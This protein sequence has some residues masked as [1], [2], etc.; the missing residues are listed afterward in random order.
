[1]N[2]YFS[3]NKIRDLEPILQETLVKVLAKMQES[4]AAGIPIELRPLFNAAT[5]DI[6]TEYAFGECWNSLGAADLNNEFFN[7]LNSGGQMWHVSSYFPWVIAVIPSLP[8]Q[9]ATWLVPRMKLM[10]P[11]FGVRALIR[12][13]EIFGDLTWCNRR[14]EKIL[15]GRGFWTK[16]KTALHF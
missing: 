6:I 11:L 16:S 10:I 5:S 9:V 8:I 12:L 7:A 1:M 15:K 13:I 14:F 2:S 4:A 3:K